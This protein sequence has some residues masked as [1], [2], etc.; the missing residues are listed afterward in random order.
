MTRH[1]KL[2][3]KTETSGVFCGT[4]HVLQKTLLFLTIESFSVAIL[5]CLDKYI[6]LYAF[7]LGGGWIQDR[8]FVMHVP[9][10]GVFSTASLGFRHDGL[11]HLSK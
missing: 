8:L 7:F 6:H 4:L 5:C 1:E 9:E 11:L 3:Q 2:Q 10:N